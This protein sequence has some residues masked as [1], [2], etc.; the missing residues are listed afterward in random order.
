MKAI[1]LANKIITT[2]VRDHIQY[3]G[4][5]AID[6]MTM[7][8]RCGVLLGLYWYVYKL[9]GGIIKGIPF[10]YAAWSIFFYFTFSVFRLRDIARLI[11]QDV[12]SGNVEVLLSK[13]ISYLSYRIWWQIGAGLYSFAFITI[14]STIILALLIG[15]PDTM[16]VN[17]FLPTLVITLLFCTVLNILIYSV[18]G[19][20]AFWIE[21]VVPVFWI[22]N[23][24]VM[25]LGG[26]YLPVAL[27]PEFMQKL[28]TYSPFGAS[29]FITHTVYA[30][31][32]TDWPRLLSIQA[33]WIIVLSIAVYFMFNKAKVN[34]SVNGG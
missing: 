23:K 26:S 33:V 11:M 1:R 28:A 13:P 12:Q 8:A 24:A 20:L 9:N 16:T 22:V 21:D 5:L 31:W 32:Q 15:I 10:S 2:Q 3:P 17:I 19:L 4:R 27:F 25:I 34:V 29:F 6:T 30:T 14:L 7:V 18:V